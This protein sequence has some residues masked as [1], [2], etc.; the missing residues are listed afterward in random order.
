MD[1][2]D[3]SSLRT[4]SLEHYAFSHSD[5]LYANVRRLI[6]ETVTLPRHDIQA[7][8]A[9]V[10]MLVP[11]AL[12]NVV[13]ILYCYGKRG[14]GKSTL[15]K[16]ASALYAVTVNNPGTTF[17]SVRNEYNKNRWADYTNFLG[18]KN[19]ILLFDNVNKSTFSDEKLYNL[20]LV[21]YDRK[22]DKM[23]ISLGNGENLYFYVFGT[24]IMSSIHPHYNDAQLSELKRRVYPL[25]HKPID[26]LHQSTELLDVDSLDL[27]EYRNAIAFYWNDLTN[28]KSYL[29][30][31]QSLKY[32]KSSGLTREQFLI[33]RDV[34]A[35]GLISKA[36][37]SVDNAYECLTEYFA[38]TAGNKDGHSALSQ[39]IKIFLAKSESNYAQAQSM[40]IAYPV[41]FPPSELKNALSV[42]RNNGELLDSPRADDVQALLR[43]SGY[44]L[45]PYEGNL[46]WVR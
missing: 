7:T 25:F 44:R 27:K 37:L 2:L 43:E 24:K 26:D 45:E 15:L 39:V 20:F 10:Y 33:S 41:G 11:S 28:A 4:D 23:S 40:G 5:S 34:L 14:S 18:E 46:R 29:T 13:P 38:L 6:D 12:A 30:V 19:T 32:K 36:W 22:T 8:I 3:F 35:T 16:L 1:R 42:A 31:R 9:S 17:A 21:G